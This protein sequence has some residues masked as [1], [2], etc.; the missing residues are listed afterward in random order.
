MTREPRGLGDM[1]RE[2]RKGR[3]LT[4]EELA[5]LVG[6]PVSAM[7]DM[8]RGKVVP[9][10]IDLLTAIAYHLELDLL[11]VL[12]YAILAKRPFNISDLHS[13]KAYGEEL[14]RENVRPDDNVVSEVAGLSLQDI[15]E[16]ADDFRAAN[17]DLGAGDD[18]PVPIMDLYKS[19]TGGPKLIIPLNNSLRVWADAFDLAEGSNVEGETTYRADRRLLQVRLR[20]D[21]WQLAE[22][23]NPRARFSAAHELGHAILH[24]EKLV[25]GAGARLFRDGSIIPSQAL[26]P[27]QKIYQSPEWQ[28]NS[29]ASALLMPSEAV[30]ARIRK[31]GDWDDEDAEIATAFGV[32]ISAARVRLA[33]LQKLAARKPPE[34]K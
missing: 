29:W 32:S 25:E 11:D 20:S 1:I 13:A 4:L 28:A 14:L 12:S 16:S 18:R 31:L 8:E 24:H 22:A 23:G 30:T 27:G 33:N 19:L 10:D 9:Q 3:D 7:A 6:K 5:H 17:F 2:A 15:E 26:R 34:T 21:V